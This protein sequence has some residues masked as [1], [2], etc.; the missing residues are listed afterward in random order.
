LSRFPYF[1]NEII[2]L[3]IEHSYFVGY[4]DLSSVYSSYIKKSMQINSLKNMT[5]FGEFSIHPNKPNFVQ[6][7]CVFTSESTVEFI[8]QDLQG[9]VRKSSKL[10]VD[11]NTKTIDLDLE[12]ISTESLHIWLYVNS[13]AFLREIRVSEDAH[14]P[15]GKGLSLGRLFKFLS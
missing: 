13:Q 1:R 15:K 6:V 11:E 2:L 7:H 5:S 4:S 9:R 14:P 10:R 8:V 3:S 12:G